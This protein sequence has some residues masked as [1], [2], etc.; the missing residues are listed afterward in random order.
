[1]SNVSFT[2]YDE[3]LV[4]FFGEDA[5]STCKSLNNVINAPEDECSHSLCFDV[6]GINICRACGCEIEVLDFQPE[7]RY[8]GASDTR[9]SKD[10]SR[11]HRS[12]ESTR[13]GIDKVF[14]DA[15][16]GHLPQAIRK[17]TEQKYKK[18][19]GGETVRGRGRMS[20]VAACLLNTFR[21]EGDIR[22]ADEVGGLFTLTKQEMSTG[23]T[24]YHATFP[25]SRTINIKPSDLIRRIMHLTK[26]DFTH[27]RN[28][29][30][31]AKCL[32]KVDPVLNRS[33][34]QSVASS[35]VYLYLCLPQEDNETE[36][37]K[38]SLR[39]TMGITKTKFARDVNLSDITITKLVKRA[40]EV[41]GQSVDM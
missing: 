11:C 17:K 22:T 18:I 9:T 5:A 39:K 15:K 31:I 40:A 12:K 21:D 19:V 37:E 16:L 23:L 27:Y 33:S 4:E 30:R 7:W 35:I 20:I 6:D 28:I 3:E 36:E 32:E 29:F 8:Y 14:Q 24:R 13:G 2:P 34:P 1:M 38:K 26:I 41:I 10:P 25:E